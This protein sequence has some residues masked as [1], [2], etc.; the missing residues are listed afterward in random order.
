[1][2]FLDKVKDA[3]GKAADQALAALN[4]QDPKAPVL[5][6]PATITL[7]T[8]LK[9]QVPKGSEESEKLAPLEL[10]A[11]LDQRQA[12]RKT[13]DFKRADVIRD[14]LKA[15]GWQIEDTPKGPRL[16]PL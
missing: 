5:A 6:P 1:M 8:Q 12:A 14:E 16:K 11:L 3:A 15:K 9:R 10:L 2:G 13:K 4:T 7:A